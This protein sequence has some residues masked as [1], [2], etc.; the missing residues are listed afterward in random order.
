MTLSIKALTW[1]KSIAPMGI[2]L[3]SGQPFEKRHN[4]I[5]MCPVKFDVNEEPPKSEEEDEWAAFG[6]MF[7]GDAAAPDVNLE[8]EMVPPPLWDRIDKPYFYSAAGSMAGALI[9]Y[10]AALAGRVAYDDLSNEGVGNVD[11]LAQ[12]RSQTNT[13]FYATV[14]VGT[15]AVALYAIFY[16]GHS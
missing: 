11:D 15:V 5:K 8:N 3:V 1:L 10:S 7:G 4:W 2:L 16:Q 14:G 13:L 12:L 9:T 6:D